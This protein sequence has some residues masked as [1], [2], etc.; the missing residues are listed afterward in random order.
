MNVNRAAEEAGRIIHECWRTRTVIDQLPAACRPDSL[1]AGYDMQRAFVVQ[2][3]ETPAGWKIAATSRAGQ[4]HI[5]VDGPIAGRLLAGRIH[6][7][8]AR[9]SLNGNR[10]AVAE[11]EFAF[12][13]GRPLPARSTPYSNTEVMEAVAAVHPAIEIPDSRYRD[14]ARAGGPQLVADNACANQFILG[15]PAVVEWRDLLLAAHPVRLLIDGSEVS[16]GTGADALGDPCAALAWLA[17][18]H[19]VQGASL[20]AGDVVTTGVCGQPST[21]RPGAG[22]V[23]DFGV[24]GTAEVLLED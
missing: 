20:E 3:G 22:V 13:L 17:N 18:N 5:N 11:A 19:A 1:K 7:S 9:V 8:P 14:F 23:A 24:F 16:R 2:S 6:H 10:M 12:V 21:I 15:P 4:L